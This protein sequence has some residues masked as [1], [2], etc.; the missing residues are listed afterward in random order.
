MQDTRPNI[1]LHIERLVLDGLPIDRG[2]GPHV[3]AAVE[4]ELTRLLTENG[5]DATW[6]T[7]GAVPSVNATGVQLSPGSSP[8]QIGRQIAQ[9]VYGGIGYAR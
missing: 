6:G 2:Q 9:S 1:H 3:Q 5:L 4:A 7:G 8:A